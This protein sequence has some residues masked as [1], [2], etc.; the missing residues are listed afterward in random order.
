MATGTEAT[1]AMVKF[2]LKHRWIWDGQVIKF[3]VEEW[4]ARIPTDV[5]VARCNF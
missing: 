4:W 5:S 2:I 1:C 3:F